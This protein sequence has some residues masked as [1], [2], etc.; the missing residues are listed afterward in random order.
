MPE[1]RDGRLGRVRTNRGQ[2]VQFTLYVHAPAT[3]WVSV[4]NGLVPPEVWEDPT[5]PVRAAAWTQPVTMSCVLPDRLESLT[6]RVAFHHTHFWALP[7]LD[8]QR[9]LRLE[10]Q[11]TTGLVALAVNTQ[12]RAGGVG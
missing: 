6:H 1:G 12:V 9:I 8:E 5:V 7:L 4:N 2:P 11:A 10:L 3:L